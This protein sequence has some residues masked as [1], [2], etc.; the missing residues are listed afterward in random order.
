MGLGRAVDMLRF[1]RKQNFVDLADHARDAGQWE[2]AAELYRKALARGP[3]SSPIW[4]QYG[5]ALKESGQ[6]RDPDR[7]AQAEVAY[8]RALALDPAAAD[9]HLQLAHALKLQGETEE[10]QAGYLRAFALDPSVL[11]PL[12]ELRGLGWSQ[13]QAAEL[14]SLL[15][16][17]PPVIAPSVAEHGQSYPLPGDGAQETQRDWPNRFGV[18]RRRYWPWRVPRETQRDWS[19]CF[20]AQWYL[21]QNRDVARGGMDPFEH[22]LT[23]GLKER[24]KPSASVMMAGAWSA[25]TSAEIHCLK[26]PSLRDE[27]ALFATYSP[28]GQ[29]KAHVPHYLESLK[30]QG[31]S[32]VLIVNTDRPSQDTKISF[33]NGI[34][35]VFVRQAEGYDFASWAHV[36][37]LHP[38]F[39]GAKILYL[40][41]D[42]V[43]GPTN[44]AA[45]GLV[46]T[47]I[48]DN[49]A[50]LIGLTENF[51][52]G[53]HLQSYFLAFKNRAL[54]SPA[55]RKFV[56]GIVSYEDK[57]DVI[58]ELELRLAPTLKAAGLDC[59]ALFPAAPTFS[60]WKQLLQSGF[61]FVK[62]EVI[63][64]LVPEAD[65]S[66]WR[67]LLGAQGY[68]VSLAE[69]TVAELSG[70]GEPTA[71]ANAS[72]VEHLVS[73]G[74]REN[75][76]DFS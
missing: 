18:Q 75:E 39:F 33:A 2:L 56:N 21:E 24:R 42:S 23:H 27:V 65:I 46:L 14:Q 8:R 32:V 29:L 61:P 67:E 1:R 62:V 73:Q 44:D 59:Q 54:S 50:D 17:G 9:T 41:N 51:D 34:D 26:Q 38:E 47:K 64:G 25:V 53:W 11:Y 58:D 72:L 48:R 45:F 68:N 60:H 13:T 19:E 6:L 55:F 69:R 74:L 28:Y 43:I 52:R 66:D 35:G 71:L 15:A 63:R 76:R 31:I 12:E 49:G 36:L 5:H 20:D 22:F 37:R 30:R 40:I 10:A 7:L 57:L 70:I 3:Q 16:D 4:V